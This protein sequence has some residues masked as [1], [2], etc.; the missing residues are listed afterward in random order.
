MFSGFLSEGRP[1][2]DDEGG[3][4]ITAF[5]KCLIGM[6]FLTSAFYLPYL[7]LRESE[8]DV[9][10]KTSGKI[11]KVYSLIG[12]NKLVTS[13]LSIVGTF[14]MGWFFFGRMGEDYGE[15][16]LAR[17]GS[18]SELLAI[19]RVGSS[20][21]VD[22]VIFAAFQGWLVTDDMKR[23]GVNVK[24]LGPFTESGLREPNEAER[25]AVLFCRVL[26]FFGM[27]YYFLNRPPLV[28]EE[29]VKES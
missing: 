17:L 10:W 1:E 24:L 19:D 11:K 6:Q 3:E 2:E 16:I 23:R 22:L 5:A 21:I 9:E 7:A 20:F 4:S 15:T 8:D 14:S 25:M 12:E 18:L 27:A 26:P 29:E 28:V 13:F